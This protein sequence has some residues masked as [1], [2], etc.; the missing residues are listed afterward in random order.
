[1]FLIQKTKY[2]CS[3]FRTSQITSTTIIPHKTRLSFQTKPG[4]DNLPSYLAI[5]P[6][7]SIYIQLHK[8]ALTFKGIEGKTAAYKSAI[9]NE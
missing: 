1:M 6:M 5:N 4:C 8:T 7:I 9:D 2:Y 3:T